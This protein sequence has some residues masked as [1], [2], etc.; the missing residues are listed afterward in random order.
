VKVDGLIAFEDHWM[1]ERYQTLF[2]PLNELFGT[3]QTIRKNVSSDLA[4]LEHLFDKM[5]EFSQCDHF[6][7]GRKTDSI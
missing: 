3:I 5:I 7:R 6:H 1:Q 4:L 2:E